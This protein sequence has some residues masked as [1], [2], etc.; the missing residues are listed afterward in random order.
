VKSSAKP[1]DGEAVRRRD[2]TSPLRSSV[3]LRS[4]PMRSSVR[5]NK[6]QA[7]LKLLELRIVGSA[8]GLT[9]LDVDAC[10]SRTSCSALFVSRCLRTR[11]CNC[12]WQRPSSRFIIILAH[13]DTFSFLCV[14]ATAAA[15]WDARA[16][17]CLS[18]GVCARGAL[19]WH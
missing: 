7:F 11:G 6:L 13:R 2:K 17:R 18:H 1:S 16:L 8:R 15:S 4:S 3:R 12:G 9:G 5:H 10:A 14:S 19:T